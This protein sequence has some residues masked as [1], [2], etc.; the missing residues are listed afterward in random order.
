V[1]AQK[2]LPD[3]SV[4]MSLLPDISR[5]TILNKLI[6]IGYRGPYYASDNN[7]G[8]RE[9]VSS[10]GGRLY[11]APWSL[12]FAPRVPLRALLTVL[13]LGRTR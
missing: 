6:L 4:D 10:V 12:E 5:N 8:S 13:Q 7:A 1:I 2:R 3:F 9:V 11:L